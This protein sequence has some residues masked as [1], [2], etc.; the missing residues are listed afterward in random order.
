MHGLINLDK[1][2]TIFHSHTIVTTTP[3]LEIWQPV[4]SSVSESKC[5]VVDV[6]SSSRQDDDR[7]NDRQLNELK[8]LCG[9][10]AG[11]YCSSVQ[12]DF[13]NLLHKVRMSYI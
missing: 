1:W 10:K 2:S 8:W 5:K 7:V 4:K 9:G 3:I 13:A 6:C 12:Q 11:L